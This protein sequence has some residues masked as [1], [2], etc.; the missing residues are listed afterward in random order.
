MPVNILLKLKLLGHLPL[1]KVKKMA[2]YFAYCNLS[3]SSGET[4]KH[5]IHTKNYPKAPGSKPYIKHA[6]C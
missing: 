1:L 2:L 3:A 5:K 6:V 4:L